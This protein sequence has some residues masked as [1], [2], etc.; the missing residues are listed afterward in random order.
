MESTCLGS[1]NEVST[2]IPS[3]GFLSG[4]GA[5]LGGAKASGEPGALPT[6][7]ALLGQHSP[8][9]THSGPVIKTKEVLFPSV[10]LFPPWLRKEGHSQC[11]TGVL[12]LGTVSGLQGPTNTLKHGCHFAGRCI[13]L[14]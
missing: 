7:F 13:F 14:D 5:E 11:N 6:S 9:H 8:P 12:N 4:L 1:F 2:K 10:S 3:L